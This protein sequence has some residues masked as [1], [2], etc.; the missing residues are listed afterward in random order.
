[1][2]HSGARSARPRSLVVR[3]EVSALSSDHRLW[4][5]L[6]PRNDTA[7]DADIPLHPALPPGW[8]GNTQDLL[9]HLNAGETCPIQLFYQAPGENFKAPPPTLTWTALDHGSVV[10]KVMLSVYL[11]FD[12]VPR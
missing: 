4:V 1:M 2:T 5:P 6:L 7:A 11:E 8:T 3:Q 9:Y 10:G 12:G